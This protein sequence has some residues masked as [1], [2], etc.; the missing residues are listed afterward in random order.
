MRNGLSA[1]IATAD[2]TSTHIHTCIGVHVDIAKTCMSVCKYRVL[3]ALSAAI[4]A[5]DPLYMIDS[6]VC[7][8]VYLR[9]HIMRVCHRHTD[10]RV[11]FCSCDCQS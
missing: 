8:L 10:E 4:A 5:A 11:E 6:I 7:V 1:A 9:V 2:P 3:N